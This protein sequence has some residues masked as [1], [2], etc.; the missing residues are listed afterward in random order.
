[1]TYNYYFKKFKINIKY[2]KKNNVMSN[3]KGRQKE[4]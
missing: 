2:L 4:L 3:R 1:M